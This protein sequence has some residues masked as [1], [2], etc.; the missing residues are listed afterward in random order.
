M[1]QIL[2]ILFFSS[3]FTSNI[4]ASLCGARGYNDE[5]FWISKFIIGSDE[6]SSGPS[7]GYANFTVD[8]SYF[9]FVVNQNA[10]QNFEIV[11]GYADEPV[12]QYFAVWIDFN[13]D[14]D[15]NDPGE[16]VYMSYGPVLYG[17]SFSTIFPEDAEVGSTIM[18]VA[19]RSDYFP[20]Y[21]GAYDYGEVEDYT[22]TIVPPPVHC[23]SSGESTHFEHIE[24]VKINADLV[25]T[26]D[27]GGYYADPCQQST[28]IKGADN[29][30]SLRP[31]FEATVYPETWKVWIDFNKNYSFDDDEL[32]METLFPVYE[33]FDF[34]YM[35]PSDVSA[36]SVYTMR[37]S[38]KF[39][40][41]VSSPCGVFNYGEV[42]DHLV[43]ITDGSGIVSS[44][45]E[46]LNNRSRKE[47]TQ[48]V[49]KLEWFSLSPNPASTEV[50]IQTKYDRDLISKVSIYTVNGD[51]VAELNNN[52]SGN[53]F[54]IDVSTFPVGYYVLSAV[55]NNKISASPFV[56]AR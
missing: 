41:P 21:C 50:T 37:V 22:I 43:I 27:N 13:H 1:R 17:V 8:N 16:E 15:F 29:I 9:D 24:A 5:P 18:R 7:G 2:L 28:L 30:I 19:M 45:E 11:A 26:G 4:S 3:F 52:T 54:P 46:K 51:L 35:I 40:S 31:G 56:I 36:G 14:L 48:K 33:D 42:E 6:R 20:D 10:C 25:T 34:T 47:K 12:K 55:V 44:G 49:E 38:M 39:G 53:E 32:V 23:S